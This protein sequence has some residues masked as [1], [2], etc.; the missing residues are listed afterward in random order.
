MNHNRKHCHCGNVLTGKQS[1]YCSRKCHNA[2]TNN[3]YQ[4]YN[5]QQARGKARKLELILRAGGCCSSCGYNKNL[6][7]LCFHH[8]DPKKKD[9][10]MDLRRL[11]NNSMETL[12]LEFEKCILLCANC[13]M[14]EHYPEMNLTS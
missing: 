9:I 12:L 10:P 1:M 11:S 4:N 6:A 2:S 7:A 8:T 3:R 5:S 14:E 13:H